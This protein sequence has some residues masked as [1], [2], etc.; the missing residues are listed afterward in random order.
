MAL[1]LS[2]F[3]LM[4]I[5]ILDRQYIIFGV[6]F[7]VFVA[8]IIGFYYTEKYAIKPILPLYMFSQPLIEIFYINTI[9]FI[10]T[11]AMQFVEP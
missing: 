3:S 7:A 8:S 9:N 4:V 11:V 5:F 2:S 10:S 6:L 1:M